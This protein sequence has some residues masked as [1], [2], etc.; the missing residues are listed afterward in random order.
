MW[1]TKGKSSM[2]QNADLFTKPLDVDK[3]YKRAKAVLNVMCCES[4]IYRGIL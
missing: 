4:N 1:R 3:F 2:C